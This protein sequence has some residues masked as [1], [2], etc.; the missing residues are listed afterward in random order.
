MRFCSAPERASIRLF[1]VLLAFLFLVNGWADRFGRRGDQRVKR[2]KV[3]HLIVPPE[4][5]HPGPLND[6]NTNDTGRAVSV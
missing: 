3:L 6:L 4:E 5:H 1:G 2:T